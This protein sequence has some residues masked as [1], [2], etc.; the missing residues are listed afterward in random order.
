[1]WAGIE[2]HQIK[3]QLLHRNA[4]HKPNPPGVNFINMFTRRFSSHRSQKQT[5]LQDLAVFFALW[6]SV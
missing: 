6:G 1:M 3:D 2:E 5:K 4:K